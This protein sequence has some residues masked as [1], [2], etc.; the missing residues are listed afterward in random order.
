[1]SLLLAANAALNRKGG[2]A[3]GVIRPVNAAAVGHNHRLPAA[4][5][6]GCGGEAGSQGEDQRVA[7]SP[8]P[9]RFLSVPRLDFDEEQNF[10]LLS[11]D[12][13]TPFSG[14]AAPP[15]TVQHQRTVPQ[16][17][18]VPSSLGG[19]GGGGADGGADGVGGAPDGGSDPDGD[20]VPAVTIDGVLASLGLEGRCPALIKVLAQSLT[21]FSL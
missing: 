16:R 5:P 21:C 2:V 7:L 13:Q 19:A 14:F 12:P 20:L 10:G 8:P 3:P 4:A 1:M 11:L 9:P 6:E 18:G 15:R 17:A